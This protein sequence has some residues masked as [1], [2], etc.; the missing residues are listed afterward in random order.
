MGM[1]NTM[2]PSAA[3]APAA[4]TDAVCTMAAPTDGSRWVLSSIDYSY[5]AAPTGGQITITYGTTTETYYVNGAGRGSLTFPQ[6]KRFPTNTGVVI[7][8]KSGGGAVIGTIYPNAW[9]EV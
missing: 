5:S 1:A 3:Q 8:L 4:A 7:T 9:T 6:E 2:T